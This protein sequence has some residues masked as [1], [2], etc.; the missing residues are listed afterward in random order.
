MCCFNK[1]V[2]LNMWVHVGACQTKILLAGLAGP[3]ESTDLEDGRENDSGNRRHRQVRT[4]SGGG[5]RRC[6]HGRP[7]VSSDVLTH[8]A[9]CPPPWSKRSTLMLGLFVS[10]VSTSFSEVG[11]DMPVRSSIGPS[12]G[13]KLRQVLAGEA[14]DS[15][16]CDQQVTMGN[17]GL[18]DIF[19]PT[20][21]VQSAMHDRPA[22]SWQVGNLSH[23]VNKL[24]HHY[25]KQD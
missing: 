4:T 13:K 20:K 1:L 12:S 7:S 18:K 5:R 2:D 15:S 11:K 8:N 24:W 6:S 16:K 17:D 3:A 25:A 21:I 19:W 23:D 14:T 22:V 9:R 10:N